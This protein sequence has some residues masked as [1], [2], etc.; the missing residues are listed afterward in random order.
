MSNQDAYGTDGDTSIY[1]YPEKR[2]EVVTRGGPAIWINKTPPCLP[3][4]DR[5]GNVSRPM[6]QEHHAPVMHAV[7][8]GRTIRH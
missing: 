1:S 8:F 5:V 3:H 2:L 7:L 4:D 6:L